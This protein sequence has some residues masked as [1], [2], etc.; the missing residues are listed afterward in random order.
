MKGSKEK[1][2]EEIKRK[3][4]IDKKG[5]KRVRRKEGKR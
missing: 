2:N 1:N 3:R 4:K 5:D